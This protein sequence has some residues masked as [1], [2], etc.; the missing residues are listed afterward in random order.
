MNWTL[1]YDKVA[2]YPAPS[3]V[4]PSL[5]APRDAPRFPSAE[6]LIQL[7]ALTGNHTSGT[8][9]GGSA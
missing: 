7:G 3:I 6:W 5:N 1:T 4:L 8:D 2:F 9:G